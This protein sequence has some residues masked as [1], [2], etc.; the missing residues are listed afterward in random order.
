M[1]YLEDLANSQNNIP[2]LIEVA[3]LKSNLQI[4]FNNQE[5][6][7]EI[8]HNIQ[9]LA[10]LHNLFTLQRNI[11]IEIEKVETLIVQ[12]EQESLSEIGSQNIIEKDVLSYLQ[13]LSKVI[14]N[15]LLNLEGDA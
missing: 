1:Q 3:M 13:T 15:N 11:E 2:L 14:Q 7:L 6:A 9:V 10:K 4:A 12:L 8:L 5:D